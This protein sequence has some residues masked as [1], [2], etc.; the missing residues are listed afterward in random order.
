MYQEHRCAQRLAF[1]A[2]AEVT[3][4]S[5]ERIARV[6][7]LSVAGAYL[8]MTNPFSKQ[9]SVLIKIR[10]S[11]EFFQCHATVA[12]STHGI[13]MGVRFCDISPPFLLVLQEWLMAAIYTETTCG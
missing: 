4:S 12:H 3:D 9:A 10:T 11:T 13:G 2:N 1:V 6:T 8:A 7:N 5:D